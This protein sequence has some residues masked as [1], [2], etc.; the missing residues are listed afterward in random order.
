VS[1]LQP[2]TVN[3]D[4]NAL[5][6]IGGELQAA[7][8]R[9]FSGTLGEW[10]AL[11]EDLERR[12]D[13]T[14]RDPDGDRERVAEMLAYTRSAVDALERLAREGPS[15]QVHIGPEE[16][17]WSDIATTWSHDEEA[18]R[19]LWERVKQSA[20]D[21]LRSGKAGAMAIEGLHERP[22][23]R[24]EYLAVWAALADGLQPTNGTE[25]LLIDAMAQALMMQRRWLVRMVQT[26]SLDVVR[27]GD[28]AYRDGYAPPRLSEAEAVDRAAAMQD[29]FHRQF[30]RL[31][32]TYRDQRRLFA[33]LVVSGGQVNI[34]QQ[35]IIA[36]PQTSA[37]E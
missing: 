25:R 35:Q 29:R 33:T 22:I 9:Y 23:L 34:A 11:L 18:G 13:A 26:D 24:A 12:Y 19:A 10:R 37:F 16:V 7:L 36:P 28:G 30:L 14:R 4:E 2:A 27:R 6:E 32:K 3:A 31:L 20:R 21:E 15:V 1:Q 8:A 5:A 17:S